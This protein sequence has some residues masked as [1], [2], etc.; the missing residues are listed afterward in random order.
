MVFESV[1][2]QWTRHAGHFAFVLRWAEVSFQAH[3][4]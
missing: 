2:D 3:K 4:Q 1:S